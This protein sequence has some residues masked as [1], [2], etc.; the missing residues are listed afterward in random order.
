M[1]SK[2]S[3]VILSLLIGMV[4]LSQNGKGLPKAYAYSRE[5]LGG[6]NPSVTTDEN[7]GTST[8]AYK[9]A[10]QYF[11]YLEAATAADIKS[12]WVEG[13]E[14]SITK[15]RVFT[16]VIIQ[17]ATVPGNVNDTLVAATKYSVWQIQL[18]DKMKTAKN[19]AT[20]AQLVRSNAVVIVYGHKEKTFQLVIKKIKKLSP[21]ALS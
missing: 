8:R 15:E 2:V 10:V 14:F 12:V 17:N 19:N 9:P 16:P 3:G 7:G 13:S 4:A 18:K 21:V 20:V 6:K 1:G 11:I 5:I